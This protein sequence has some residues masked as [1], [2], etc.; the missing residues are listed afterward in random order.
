MSSDCSQSSRERT[1]A[2]HYYCGGR[3]RLPRRNSAR[4]RDIALT[5]TPLHSIM[6][7]YTNR[8]TVLERKLT[9]PTDLHPQPTF[10]AQHGATSRIINSRTLD[11][12][13]EPCTS[14]ACYPARSAWAH[15]WRGI[16]RTDRSGCCVDAAPRADRDDCGRTA[17]GPSQRCTPL[18]ARR[19]DVRSL[20]NGEPLRRA[21]A[22]AATWRPG[23]RRQRPGTFSVL[24][25]R[26]GSTLR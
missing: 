25:N 23:R 4:S 15:G 26:T 10:C 17:G 24:S 2:Y 7:V 13:K 14:L 1:R 18:L 20:H 12:Q 8:A 11:L 6:Q 22:E 3:P 21:Q 16:S 19:R 5:R 9:R